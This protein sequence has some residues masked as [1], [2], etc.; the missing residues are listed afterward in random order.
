MI[1]NKSLESG[2]LPDDWKTAI[3]T[4]IHKKGSKNAASNYRPVSLTCV[5]CKVLESIIRDSIVDHFKQYKLYAECQH[6]FR[7]KRSCISQLLEVIED[8]T[9]YLN[10]GEN[11]DIVYLDFRKAFDT[12]PHKRLLMKLKSYG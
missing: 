4:A 10:N 1:F 12:V 11:I 7:N 2:K 6:G 8:L 5:L 3:V 9:V